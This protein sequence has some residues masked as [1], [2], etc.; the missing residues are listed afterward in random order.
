M[1]DL[2]A[3]TARPEVISFAGG[4][5]DVSGIGA[6]LLQEI[7]AR[8]S[9]ESR[10][11]ALWYCPTEGLPETRELVAHLMEQE[12]TR[13]DPAHVLITTGGQQVLDLV[14]RTFIDPGDIVLA[15]GP[16]Y[17]GVVPVFSS[18]QA[19]VIQIP[20]D[21]HGL[22]P[23][24]VRETI[25]SLRRK[26][27]RPKYLYTIPTFQNPAGVSMTLERRKALIELA[28]REDLIIL[29]DNP[30]SLLRFEGTPLPSLR[31]LDENGRVIYLGTFSKTFAPGVRLGWAEA[32]PA[33][34]AK[35]NLAKQAA[36]LCSNSMTQ[37]VVLRFF[38]G[39]NWRSYLQ[40]AIDRTKA[41]R[42]AML[43][44]MQEHFPADAQWTRP[45]GGLFVWAQLPEFIDTTDL[46]ARA[47]RAN[48]AFVPGPSAYMDGSGAHE[49]RL[50]FSA[51]DER[52]IATGIQRLGE[53]IAEATNL[54]EQMGM[55]PKSP[56]GEGRPDA[57]F[58]EEAG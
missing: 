2:M 17:P 28:E 20:L 26:R 44:A 15:E 36:D 52:T 18:Y 53:T 41:R 38:R 46:L 13:V 12:G 56:V 3:I 5:P 50:N 8:I 47:L 6:D 48:V 29:E 21:E 1:R 11:G 34:L 16:T 25:A 40:Q 33:I 49:M 23:E 32:P 31:S 7:M 58:V 27:R 54:A 37:H 19:D 55:A 14:A 57:G 43:T 42:D 51:A 24:A 9:A 35:L 4:L 30:Y 10:T 22:D 45:E 39:Y